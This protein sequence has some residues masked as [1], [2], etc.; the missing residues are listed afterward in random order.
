MKTGRVRRT[1]LYSLTLPY[2]IVGMVV[3]IYFGYRCYAQIHFMNQKFEEEDQ[4]VLSKAARE[5]DYLIDDMNQL[6]LEIELNDRLMRPLNIGINRDGEDNYH[7]AMACRE[8]QGIKKFNNLIEDVFVYYRKSNLFLR[9]IGIGDEYRIWNDYSEN[10]VIPF[11][12]WKGNLSIQDFFGTLISVGD[13]IYY[14]KTVPFNDEEE[15]CN[16]IIKINEKRFSENINSFT[17]ENEREIVI[18]DPSFEI[19][20]TNYHLDESLLNDVQAFLTTS[21]EKKWTDTSKIKQSEE[22]YVITYIHEDEEKPYYVIVSKLSQV[23]KQQTYVLLMYVNGIVV[24]GILL[25]YGLHLMEKNYKDI[26]QVAERLMKASGKE[27]KKGDSEL[28]YINLAINGMEEII[29]N[30]EDMVVDHCVRRAIYGLIENGDNNYKQLLKN[31]TIMC[32]GLNI[33]AIFENM[34]GRNNEVKEI[35]LNLFIIENVLK[36]VLDGQMKYRVIPLCDWEIVILSRETTEG[37][38]Y[39]DIKKRLQNVRNYLK[40]SLELDYAVSMSD[41]VLGIGQLSSAYRD[42][43]RAIETARIVGDGHVISSRTLQDNTDLLDEMDTYEKRLENM[44]RSGQYEKAVGTMNTLLNQAFKETAVS[45]ETGKIVILNLI[46]L[47]NRLKKEYGCAGRLNAMVILKHGGSVHEIRENLDIEIR[48]LCEYYTADESETRREQ[49]KQ[50]VSEHY[51]DINLNVAMIAEAF[52]L[53][54]TYLS[55]YFKEE[56]GENLLSYVNRYRIEQAKKLLDT[57]DET[58]TVIASQTG[59]IN[60]ASLIRTFKKYEGITPG[61]YKEKQLLKS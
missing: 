18:V 38:T 15:N 46:K 41:E 17:V 4:N 59:F 26:R 36:D 52:N 35:K 7:I 55:R 19:I 60:I 13:A 54:A 22:E 33:I 57:T 44:I 40:E 8:L 34:A 12:Q 16:I 23:R 58:V 49:I 2:L 1:M 45:P 10:Q 30:Q 29:Q 43:V 9:G 25:L 37:E 6:T 3:I 24:L 53:N 32:N 21:E 61:Q 20:K 50:Y 28:D 47:V 42:A 5:L 56:T 48:Q 11:D 51:S 14:I 39:D 31:E 27:M